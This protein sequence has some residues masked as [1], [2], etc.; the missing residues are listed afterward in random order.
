MPA[1]PGL[2]ANIGYCP[3]APTSP[4]DERGDELRQSWRLWS[5]EL[6]R[7]RV[8]RQMECDEDDVIR[9]IEMRKCSEHPAYWLAVW[10]WIYEPRAQREETDERPFLPYGFQIDTL[11]F[12]LKTLNERGA[13]ADGIISKSRDMGASWLMCAFALWG[14]IFKKPWQVRLISRNQDLVDNKSSDSLFWKLDF[15]WQRLP[16]W[17]MPEGFDPIGH[18]MKLTLINPNNGNMIVGESTT[19]NAVRGGRATWVGYDEAAFIPDFDLAWAATANATNHRFAVS[20]ESLEKGPHFYKLRT[21]SDMQ[22]RPSVL[23]LDWWQHPGH[24][25]EWLV[26]MKQRFS[27]NPEE[28]YAEVL[29]DPHTGSSTWVYPSA[30]EKKPVPNIEYKNGNPIIVGVDPGFNDETAIVWIQHN[31]KNGKY[32]ILNSYVNR[33]MPA[34]FYGTILTGTPTEG[35]WQYTEADYEI[36]AWTRSLPQPTY[37]GDVYGD[38]TSGATLDSFYSRLRRFGIHVNVDRVPGSDVTPYR[39][40][41]RSFKGRREALREMLPTVEFSDS[42]GSRR[43]LRAL[44]EHRFRPED[45]PMQSSP[46]TPLHDWTSHLVSALEYVAV[47]IKMRRSVVGRVLTVHSPRNRKST[48]LDRFNSE[49][50][51]STR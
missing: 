48:K 32:E 27:A 1:I 9:A 43:V 34:D 49:V 30:N 39:M 26:D 14:W 44:Q 50:T 37:Y 25:R 10:G 21:G 24:D 3:D 42:V 22:H 6:R 12:F 46:K 36:M 38:N 29:R 19:S 40:S 45:R 35:D 20:S 47:N 31:L 4:D 23:G 15:L 16:N 2:P 7:Y 33:R 8:T 18:R 11:N 13:A 41:A 5:E 28:Y 51:W 17:M